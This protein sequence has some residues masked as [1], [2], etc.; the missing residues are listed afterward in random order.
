[1]PI[2][3]FKAQVSYEAGMEFKDTPITIAKRVAAIFKSVYEL[4]SQQFPI[5]I[6]AIIGGVEGDGDNF[7]L[8]MMQENLLGFIG[9]GEHPKTSVQTVIS[10]LKPFISSNPFLSDNGEMG[11][12]ELFNHTEIRNHVFQFHKVD[13][14]SARALIEF[15]LWDLYAFVKCKILTWDKTR[16][17]RNILPRVVSTG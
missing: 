5:L 12:D 3:P 8:N 4:G 9:D 11:W 6:D 2:N 15:V 16:Q 13:K 7:D 14:H 10:K 1:M 17:L